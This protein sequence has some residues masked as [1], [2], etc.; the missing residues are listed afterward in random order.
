MVMSY[1]DN[2]GIIIPP[3]VAE[4]QV[5]IIPVNLGGIDHDERQK[6]Y[7]EIRTLQSA[8][9]S[10][11]IRA[12]SV[13]REGYSPGW[14][15][16]EWNLL[17]VPLRLNFGPGESFGNLGTAVRRDIAGEDGKSMILISNLTIGVL[18]HLYEIHNSLY[19]R[20]ESSVRS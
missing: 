2:P 3:R 19:S 6:L 9:S 12:E 18:T 20:V 13:L 5:I 7:D 16:N 4:V 17:G 10:Q 8:L 1:A 14:K 11:G 15:F